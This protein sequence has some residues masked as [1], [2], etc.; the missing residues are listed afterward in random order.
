MDRCHGLV[1]GCVS[2]VVGK[3]E[4]AHDAMMLCF[5]VYGWIDGCTKE[6]FCLGE[7]SDLSLHLIHSDTR[8]FVLLGVQ[9]CNRWWCVIRKYGLTDACIHAWMDGW[10]GEWMHAC[11]YGWMDGWMDACMYVCMYAWMD[12]WM[13][14]WVD[15]SMGERMHGW[16]N[17]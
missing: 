9:L 1:E 3:F 7:A 13:D 16:M 4:C 5:G 12:R 10:V 8:N 6:P 17:G 14:R 2:W 11:I 15:G